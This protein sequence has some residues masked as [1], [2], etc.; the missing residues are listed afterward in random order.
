MSY[1]APLG[2]VWITYAMFQVG[3]P[4]LVL[5]GTISRRQAERDFIR[6]CPAP[7]SRNDCYQIT[8][9]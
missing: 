8:R 9:E 6:H 3:V 7:L 4:A 5:G 1:I 2:L